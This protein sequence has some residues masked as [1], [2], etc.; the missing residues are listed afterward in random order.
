MT[1][2]LVVLVG[3]CVAGIDG[4]DGCGKQEPVAPKCCLTGC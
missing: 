1:A 2:P 3:G 4:A